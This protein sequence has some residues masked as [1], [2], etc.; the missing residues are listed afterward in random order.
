MASNGPGPSDDRT[1]KLEQS[2]K[3]LR[4]GLF[5]VVVFVGLA[6]LAL[7]VGV[8]KLRGDVEDG[9]EELDGDIARVEAIALRQVPVPYDGDTTW[10]SPPP[11]EIRTPPEVITPP[12]VDRHTI[13]KVGDYE[14]VIP[15]ERLDHTLSDLDTLLTQ[16]RATPLMATVDGERTIDGFILQWIKPGSVFEELGLENGDVLK[17]VNGE[18]LDSMADGLFLLRSLRGESSIVLEI[19]RQRLPVQLRYQVE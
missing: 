7:A 8:Y 9:F 15:R 13:R 10:Y 11:P 19:Q 4:V 17:S 3:S 16:A 18:K 2:V 1:A 6:I 12:P 14:Y 5:L